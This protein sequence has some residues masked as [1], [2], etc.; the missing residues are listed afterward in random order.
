MRDRRVGY[1][2]LDEDDRLIGGLVEH[3]GHTP[4]FSAHWPVR[5]DGLVIVLQ[6]TPPA[7]HYRSDITYF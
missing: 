4:A 2:T 1:W 5:Y 7:S 6:S 3:G